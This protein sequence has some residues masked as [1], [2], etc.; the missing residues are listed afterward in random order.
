MVKNEN[1]FITS[2]RDFT[3]DFVLVNNREDE[4]TKMQFEFESKIKKTLENSNG[5]LKKESLLFSLTD[6]LKVSV[7]NGIKEWNEKLIDSLPMKKLSEEY[8]DRIILLVF[9]KVNAGKSSF[10][11]FITEQFPNEEIKRFCF[12]DNRIEY[13]E[14]SFAEG[15]VETTAT[16]QGVEIGRN[17]VLLDSPGLHSIVDENG[18]LTR[19]F[20]DSADAV[21]WLTPSS[22]PGQVQ[23]LTDLKLEL[24]KKKPLL[25][26]ITRS[27]Q[28]IEDWSDELNDL[29]HT[30]VNKSESIRQL[31]EV[32]VIE[33]VKALGNVDDLKSAISISIHAYREHQEKENA[34]SQAGLNRLFSSLSDIIHEAKEYKVEKA[35]QQLINFINDNVLSTLEKDISPQLLKLKDQTQ[36]T[37][38]DLKKK[39]SLI[40]SELLTTVKSQVRGVVE[41]HSASQDKVAISSDLN[42]LIEHELTLILQEE[43]KDLVNQINT[44]SSSLNTD[45]LGDFE[46]Q[47]V[48][49]ERIK[50]S[51]G[52]S[53]ST[54][55]GGIGGSAG[56]ALIGSMILPG[57][58]TAIGGVIGG[59]L[60]GAA[61]SAVGNYW[62]ETE[63]VEHVVGFS[64]EDMLMQIS[65][66]ITILIPNLVHYT[67]SEVRDSVLVVDRFANAILG[68]IEKFE[69][70]I[71]E[72]RG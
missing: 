25:P 71:Q 53:I 18:D 57:V 45:D 60:G 15:V 44:T 1:V 51:A 49:V 24:E 9:G 23:E 52:K 11:N 17:F 33:R 72:F 12:V 59:M 70:Q 37:L 66:K 28:L 46:K 68:E 26:I 61:G 56:G 34:Q 13:F 20:T 21:L 47:T 67:M 54:G 65:E 39:E 38:D 7:L 16:I 64:V 14:Q 2:L 58:G 32:D 50:G 55:V 10:C 27:D 40:I 8:S 63:Q 48:N 22:S 42:Q 5:K 6:A 41:Q 31:Q 62:V 19:R 69:Y 30:I 43:L 4:L 35:N 29:V 3:G 36:K